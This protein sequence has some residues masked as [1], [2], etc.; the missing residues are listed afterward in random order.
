M[1]SCIT[2]EKSAVLRNKLGLKVY[3]LNTR[4]VQYRRS[5]QDVAEPPHSYL[6]RGSFHGATPFLQDRA[7]I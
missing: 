1:I 7:I 3:C 2:L 6:P 4:A 5:R